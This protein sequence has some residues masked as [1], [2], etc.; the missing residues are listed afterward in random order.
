RETEPYVGSVLDH[1]MDADGD[2]LLF[3]KVDRIRGAGADWLIVNENG[4]LQGIPSLLEQGLHIWTIQVADIYGGS[5]TATLMI[6][7]NSTGQ[8]A[9]IA[10]FVDDFPSARGDGYQS[11]EGEKVLGW[12]YLWN[13]GGI[14]ADSESY[15]SLLPNTVESNHSFWDSGVFTALGDY[16]FDDTEQGDFRYGRIGVG[17]E[18]LHPGGGENGDFQ[19]I[20]SYTVQEGEAG[21]VSITDSFVQRAQ[22][23]GEVVL[24]V[25]VN[26]TFKWNV[27]STGDAQNFDGEL[28]ILEP[29]DTIYVKLGKGS[30][31]VEWDASTMDFTLESIGAQVDSLRIFRQNNGLA[32]DGTDDLEDMSGNGIANIAYFLFGLGDPDSPHVEVLRSSES[33]TTGLPILNREPNGNLVFTYT[34]RKRQTAYSYIVSTSSDLTDWGNV[35]L[36]ETPYRPTDTT[37]EDVN[38][39]YEFCHLSFAIEEGSRFIRIEIQNAGD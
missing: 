35:E 9:V 36:V 21:I 5:D 38:S 6:A 30:D 22:S 31:G 32:M 3:S 16:A 19:A 2:P 10:D 27:T 13:P 11:T 15:V 33:P 26:D 39:D 34:R 1:A 29:G 37:I 23:G 12:N 24:S 7:V 28:G 4:S 18:G 20:A 17:L 25:Y 14:I 8:P